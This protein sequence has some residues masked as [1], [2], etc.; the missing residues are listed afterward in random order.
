M[1]RLYQEFKEF[2]R[3]CQE[4]K[5]NERLQAEESERRQEAEKRGVAHLQ[6]NDLDTNPKNG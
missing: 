2:E 1:T 6:V 3:L 5:E 4:I